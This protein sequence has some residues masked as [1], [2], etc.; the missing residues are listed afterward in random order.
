MNRLYRKATTNPA[1]KLRQPLPLPATILAAND[2]HRTRVP[3]VGLNPPTTP[4]HPEP[5]RAGLFSVCKN[6]AFSNLF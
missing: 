4:M 3:S 6:F 2:K 5:A 1:F